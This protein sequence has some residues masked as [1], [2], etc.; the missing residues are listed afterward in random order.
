MLKTALA[1][2][3]YARTLAFL[4]SA[5]L[6][7]ILYGAGLGIYGDSL[8]GMVKAGRITELA[9]WCSVGVGGLSFLFLAIFMAHHMILLSCAVVRGD[10]NDA[11]ERALS[12]LKD[13]DA[14]RT[15]SDFRDSRQ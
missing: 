9:A 5:F 8:P 6:L 7:I 4:T 10:R 12:K 14:P 1:G 2:P 3:D 15:A 13:E 11:L